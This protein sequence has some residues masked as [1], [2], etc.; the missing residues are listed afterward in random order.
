MHEGLDAIINNFENLLDD[1][2]ADAFEMTVKS[3]KQH[4]CQQFDSIRAADTDI[5][6]HLHQGP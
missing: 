1:V 4:M 3:M 2:K 6:C 5:V